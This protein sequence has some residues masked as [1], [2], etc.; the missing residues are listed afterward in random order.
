[1]AP[2]ERPHDPRCPN[3]ESLDPI[4]TRTGPS[5]RTRLAGQDATSAV[6]D[7]SDPTLMARALP[8]MPL[9][10]RQAKQNPK[11]PKPEEQLAVRSAHPDKRHPTTARWKREKP[12]NDAQDAKKSCA[13]VK[14]VNNGPARKR[15]SVD[16]RRNGPA[17]LL[18][19]NVVRGRNRLHAKPKPL[20]KPRLL[21][22]GSAAVCAKRRCLLRP[23]DVAHAL[24]SPHQKHSTKMWTSSDAAAPAQP[25]TPGPIDDDRKQY[26]K[27]GLAHRS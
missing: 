4:A 8:P 2:C 19:K 27:N 13:S 7:P 20:L 9:P 5:P 24:K 25:M 17:A 21:N 12:K 10:P 16:V 11:T 15:R 18:G 1:M 26:R 3:D 23:S 14:H 6:A 22:A